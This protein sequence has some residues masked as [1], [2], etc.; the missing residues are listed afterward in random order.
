MKQNNWL[1]NYYG[2]THKIPTWLLLLWK[3]V[4]CRVGWH[5]FDE[6]LG[7]QFEKDPHYLS[8]DA[9]ELIVNIASI[10]DTYMGPN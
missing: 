2:L 8:C 7:E 10:D 6:V 1:D 5:A 4:F 3:K 9:C